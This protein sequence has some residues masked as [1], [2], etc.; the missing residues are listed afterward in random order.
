MLCDDLDGWMGVCGREV[1]EGYGYTY[2]RF[3]FVVQKKIKNNMVKT[4]ISVEK[5]NS[6]TQRGKKEIVVILNFH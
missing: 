3:T 2:N 1:Q 5:L 6:C 4:I